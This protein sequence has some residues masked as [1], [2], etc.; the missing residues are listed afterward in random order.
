MNIIE[1][2]SMNQS[3]WLQKKTIKNTICLIEA[4]EYTRMLI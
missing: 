2:N 1:Q 3:K 4:R